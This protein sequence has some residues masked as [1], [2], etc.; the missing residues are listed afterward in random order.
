MRGGPI[1]VGSIL[2][3]GWE[4]GGD[5]NT[6]LLRPFFLC[7]LLCTSVPIGLHWVTQCSSDLNF[8]GSWLGHVTTYRSEWWPR[9]LGVACHSLEGGGITYS[10]RLDYVK[11][12]SSFYSLHT[13]DARWSV[14]HLQTQ[15]SY[16]KKHYFGIVLE[17]SHESFLDVIFPCLPLFPHVGPC[18]PEG[19]YCYFCNE[20]IN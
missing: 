13:S 16:G 11:L 5:T 17:E 18:L 19:S 20:S 9:L 12:L 2:A 14:P 1:L 6:S 7:S 10:S 15:A 3:N 8:V 4:C